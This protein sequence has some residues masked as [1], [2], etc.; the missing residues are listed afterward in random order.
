MERIFALVDGC[1]FQGH[2]HV[3]GIF[4]EQSAGERYAFF[5][6]EEM[7]QG[8]RPDGKVL[9]N[10]GSVGQPRD[11]DWR[12]CYVLVDEGT[13]RFRRVEYDVEATVRKIHAESELDPASA[14]GSARGAELVRRTGQDSIAWPLCCRNRFGFGS[15]CETGTSATRSLYQN[16]CPPNR[17]RCPPRQRYLPEPTCPARFA[18]SR[19]SRA[20]DRTWLNS[21]AQQTTTA[22]P[23]DQ[24]PSPGRQQEA[25]AEEDHQAPKRVAG[26]FRDESRKSASPL[27]DPNPKQTITATPRA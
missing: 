14:I 2:T 26:I 3:P 12:A 11:G 18:E 13:I 8:Y 21:T 16:R 23:A 19:Q 17:P 6:P 20:D 25:Q 7:G 1:C 10:V 24:R 9:C 27:R 5:D 15:W 22:K 4:T